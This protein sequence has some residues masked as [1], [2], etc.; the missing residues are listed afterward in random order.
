MSAIASR[1][2][3]IKDTL[4]GASIVAMLVLVQSQPAFAESSADESGQYEWSAELVSFDAASRTA[5]L[6]ARM[7]ARADRSILRELSEGDRI[8]ITWT[9]LTWG[10]GIAAVSRGDSAG[11]AGK[12]QLPAEYVGTEMDDIYLVFRVRVPEGS[13]A[14]LE[15]LQPG[16]WVTATTSRD[17]SRLEQAVSEIRPY[18]DVS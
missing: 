10:A 3:K 18:N 4:F 13:A 14:K 17:A 1:L 9:G 5:T 15:A 16:A 12:L 11:S 6:K 8:T 2:A 7:D